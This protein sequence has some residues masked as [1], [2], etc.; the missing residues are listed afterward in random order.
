MP[1]RHKQTRPESPCQ[2]S[3]LDRL[4]VIENSLKKCTTADLVQ[5]IIKL[6]KSNASLWKGLEAELDVQKPVELLVADMESAIG[7]ATNVDDRNINSNFDYDFKAY[8]HVANGF[9]ELIET[10][11][12]E[13]AKEL[14]I[15]LMKDASYQ[16]ECSD[17]GLMR[18]EIEDCLKPVIRAVRSEGC[19][20]AR[21]WAFAMLL[22]D[23][24]GFICERELKRMANPP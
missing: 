23:R 21:K 5:L 4:P 14:A 12:L 8:E 19:D 16:V 20:A 2:R 10:G 24:V 17:E 11:N 18:E 3:T 7:V 9:K 22:E 15:Q 1:K 6:A 13:A